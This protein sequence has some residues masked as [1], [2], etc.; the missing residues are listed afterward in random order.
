MYLYVLVLTGIKGID[1]NLDQSPS[2]YDLDIMLNHLGPFFPEGWSLLSPGIKDKRSCYEPTLQIVL[3]RSPN[4]THIKHIHYL[5][6][7]KH[8]KDFLALWHLFNL[9]VNTYVRNF[10]FLNFL[11]S[12]SCQLRTT[13]FGE[14]EKSWLRG[15]NEIF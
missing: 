11:I 13:L 9:R 8:Q 4:E 12:G 15:L 3:E 2:T 1:M 7:T 6:E 10:N 5:H 14:I